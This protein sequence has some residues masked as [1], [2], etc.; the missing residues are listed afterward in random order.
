MVI[1]V[2]HLA[3]FTGSFPVQ[4]VEMSQAGGDICNTPSPAPNMVIPVH[5][6]AFSFICKIK[7][8]SN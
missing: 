2:H 7:I 4:R 8:L 5:H 6:L 1:P 3:C